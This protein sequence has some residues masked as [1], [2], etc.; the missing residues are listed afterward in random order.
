[1]TSRASVSF[2]REKG[3][4]LLCWVSQNGRKMSSSC[5][6]Q[7]PTGP[8]ALANSST[9]PTNL[10]TQRLPQVLKP[11]TAACSDFMQLPGLSP[12][13]VALL[14][15]TS[16]RLELSLFL[17]FHKTLSSLWGSSFYYQGREGGFTRNP[18]RSLFLLFAAAHPTGPVPQKA[19][20]PPPRRGVLTPPPAPYTIPST[21]LCRAAQQS[22]PC[23][24]P[25]S[26]S[27]VQILG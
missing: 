21:L 11:H 26:P 6:T 24:C 12:S 3:S 14:C 4:M 10:A 22:R 15:V 20:T 8:P 1:M 13:H 5:V 27:H 9:K 25:G 7:M 23:P 19:L 16:T 2:E 18:G 17:G